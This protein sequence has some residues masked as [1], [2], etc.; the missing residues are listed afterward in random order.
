MPGM[1]RSNST[2]VTPRRPM[3]GFTVRTGG[4]P[5]F[6]VAVA[7]GPDL[8]LPDAKAR[9]SA[10][11]FWSSRALGPLRAERGEAV[12][13]LPQDVLARFAGQERL[14]YA[15]AT[16][17]DASRANASVRL[18]PPEVA[19][20]VVISRSFTGRPARSLV[21]VSTRRGSGGYG[22]PGE[23]ASPSLEWAGDALRPAAE[24]PV[25]APA[26]PPAAAPAAG[27]PAA[28]AAGNGA[29]PA[30]AAAL[31]Y[32]DG[33][34]PGLWA[35]PLEEGDEAD[36]REVG[37]IPDEDDPQGAYAAAPA[38]GSGGEAG[39]SAASG[40]ARAAD[41]PAAEYGP[42]T[43]EPADP[44]NYSRVS[45]T[46]TI[47]RIVIHVTDGG[48]SYRGTVGWFQNPQSKVSAHY[49]VGQGG[50][51]VQMV[52]ENDRAWHAHHANRDSIGIEHVASRRR[53][54]FPTEAEYRASA[55]LVRHLCAKYGIPADEQHVLGHSDAD[56][57]TTH[58]DCP[59]S[60][61][62]WA[63]YRAMLNPAPQPTGNGGPAA[64]GQS[65]PGNGGYGGRLRVPA[66]VGGGRGAVAQGLAAPLAGGLAVVQNAYTPTSAADALRAQLDFQTRFQQW[67]AGVGDTS[68]FPHS[69]ICQLELSFPST[70]GTGTDLY[71]GT[72]FYIAPDRILT[73]AHNVVY[74]DRERGKVEAQSIRVV[75]GKKGAG[76][77][78]GAE[79][80]GGFTV[81]QG[82]WV[83]HKRYGGTRAFDLAVIRVG[84]APP[85]GAYF[86]ILEELNQSLPSSMVVCGYA[87]VTV[88]PDVQHLD[89]DQVRSLGEDGETLQYNLQT[90]KG[91]SGSPVYYLWG[92]EDEQEQMSVPELRVV[93][94]HVAP[95]SST[96]N[97]ACRLTA[98]KI[99][100]IRAQFTP[101]AEA[102]YGMAYRAPARMLAGAD[103]FNWDD[104]PLVGQ[105]SINSCWAAAASMLVSWRDGGPVQ[106]PR[107]VAYAAGFLQR[108]DD[109]QGLPAGDRAM[110]AAN[111]GLE[112]EAGQNFTID[113]FAELLRT[114]GPLWVAERTPSG[115]NHIVVVTGLQTDG[116]A[117]G[118]GTT[119]RIADPMGREP[120]S[121]AGPGRAIQ[122]GGLGSRYLLSWNNFSRMYEARISTGAGGGVDGQIL[123]ATGVGGRQ[124]AA[125]TSLAYAYGLAAGALAYARPLTLLS[126]FTQDK[127]DRLKDAFV[128]N[129]A[130]GG[131]K[132]NCITIVNS[133]LRAMYGSRLQNDDGSNKPLGDRIN[134]TMAKLQEYGLAQT[135]AVFE[136]LD[137]SGSLTRGVVRPDRL[138][139][140]IEAWMNAQA[141]A[142]QQSGW[143]LFGLSIMDGYHSVVLALQFN[144]TGDPSTKVYWADQIYS[145]WDDVTGGLD[146]RITSR[147]QAWW[148][149]AKVKTPDRLP[150]TRVTLWPLVP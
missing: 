128:Q 119:L 3:A 48:R 146:A 92:R 15:V 9:R 144:G 65:Y 94:V 132:Q 36:A 19:P 31:G 135:E 133:A 81:Q 45:G 75:P 129:V 5:F 16:F 68:F 131:T 112:Q 101:A 39:Y 150:R 124:P 28:P 100:W 111:L 99:A 103:D 138:R 105:V 32:D 125:G 21:G 109:D 97:N 63:K 72:G 89:G 91:A 55:A 141:D 58:T 130:A 42:A 60:A 88:D 62:D 147:T 7:A 25:A 86:E 52:R 87:G 37:E 30:H 83:Y 114:R 24:P 82:D 137:A 38:A 57:G 67:S 20:Y 106:N 126:G 59:A 53:G 49:V 77:G 22:S 79:P 17:A 76:T 40:Y 26:P 85:G 139:D 35:R 80:F 23:A 56:P 142:G 74:W 70:S 108:Y 78:G 113:A 104:V 73:A 127:V 122:A 95:L 12:Y 34:D 29:A 115:N 93:G 27:P 1:I 50:E 71:T 13:L 145:G 43:F 143:Y 4:D 149:G 120:G 11:N 121:P 69:A 64:E 117:D 123:H 33:F 134:R 102:S 148:D 110:L 66:L 8:F 44:G 46:R 41:A 6:E 54:I 10:A 14:Y 107:D 51:V 96:L 118:S 2:E 84:T 98:S 116:N 136:F 90:E 47:E 18:L 61:W 140:S